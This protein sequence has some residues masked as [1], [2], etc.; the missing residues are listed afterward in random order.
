MVNRYAELYGNHTEAGIKSPAITTLEW[1]VTLNL[2]N[3]TLPA[4]ESMMESAATGLASNYRTWFQVIS[5]NLTKSFFVVGQP[6][7]KVPLPDIGQNELLTGDITITIDE[8]IGPDTKVT[9]AA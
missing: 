3:E 8:Y 5:P 2:T 4:I 7:T 6:G 9:P 1:T